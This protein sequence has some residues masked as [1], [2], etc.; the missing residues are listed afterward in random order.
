MVLLFIPTEMLAWDTGHV[1]DFSLG[2]VGVNVG[3]TPVWLQEGSAGPC[4]HCNGNRLTKYVERRKR[5]RM[6]GH[7]M[8]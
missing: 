2:N 1:G 7:V 6:T 5:N 8:P 3:G 4:R